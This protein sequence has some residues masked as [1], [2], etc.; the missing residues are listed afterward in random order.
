MT[1]GKYFSEQR[2]LVEHVC[3]NADT[4]ES[5]EDEFELNEKSS[6]NCGSCDKIFSRKHDLQVHT[7][8]IHEGHKDHT[9]DS[10]GKFFL[11]DRALQ[12]H[13]NAVHKGIKDHKCDLCGKLFPYLS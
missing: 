13:I 1:C 8:A 3:S 12:N 2:K 5:E 7:Y 4:F 9:C 10:C 6:H 11:E